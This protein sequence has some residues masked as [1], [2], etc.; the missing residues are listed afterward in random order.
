MDLHSAAARE[1]LSGIGSPANY[2]DQ[3]MST[4][5]VGIMSARH[6]QQ[7]DHNLRITCAAAPPAHTPHASQST[8]ASHSDPLDFLITAGL[9]TAQLPQP[10]SPPR[11]SCVRRP[12]WLPP[13]HPAAGR[14]AAH[15]LQQASA[16]QGRDLQGHRRGPGQGDT[17]QG[18][19]GQEQVR[20]VWMDGGRR[21][22]HI[23]M[24]GQS[25]I[26][27]EALM[28]WAKERVH[29]MCGSF[30]VSRGTSLWT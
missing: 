10:Y 2:T 12:P 25:D 26:L 14:R 21:V 1:Q 18:G 4:H 30:D 22:S 15:R 19:R 3:E 28:A 16:D 17:G 7:L 24:R 6:A 27:C 13:P 11:S 29:P 23:C 9:R 5:P 20:F 8:T